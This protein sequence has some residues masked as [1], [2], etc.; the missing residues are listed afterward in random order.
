MAV[1]HLLKQ[2]F[3]GSM[4]TWS[5]REPYFLTLH[6]ADVDLIAVRITC[7]TCYIEPFRPLCSVI[8]G[9]PGRALNPKHPEIIGLWQIIRGP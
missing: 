2:Q 9:V 1:D 7:S 8:H 6:P 4:P 5:R 3:C